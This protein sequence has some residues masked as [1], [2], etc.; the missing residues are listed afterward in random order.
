MQKKQTVREKFI[1]EGDENTKFFHLIAKGRKRR[2]KI[3]Y[4]MQS[5]N[6]TVSINKIASSFYKD[7]LAL[8]SLPVL[9]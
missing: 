8:L 6:D 1:N 2:I 7:L 3:P 5:M 9:M 4:L